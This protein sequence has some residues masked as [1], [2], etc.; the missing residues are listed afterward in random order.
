MIPNKIIIHHSLTKDSITASWP[1]IRTYHKS[2]GWSDI[3]Y[4]FGIENI[5]GHIELISGRMPDYPGAHCHGHNHNSI[6]VLVVGNFTYESPSPEHMFKLKLLCRKLMKFFPI[7][8]IYGHGEL[9]FR[10]TCPGKMF[11]MDKLR[12]EVGVC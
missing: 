3:G 5:R 2:K 4:H 9:D 11:D 12:K 10:R 1:V 8:K 6:G 7:K